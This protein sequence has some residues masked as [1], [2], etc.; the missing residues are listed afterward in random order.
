MD[1]SCIVNG[2]SWFDDRGLPVNA[3]GGCVVE[4]DK[5]YFFGEH[6]G[7]GANHFGGF[8]CY[9]SP[10]LTAWTFERM[11]LPRQADGLL[12]PNRIG[13]RP[14]VMRCPGTGE[15]VMFM[16]CDDDG[17]ADPC[18]GY[19]MADEI[20]GEYRFR[21]PLLLDGEPVRKWDIG[22]YQAPDGT[23]YLLFHE[24]TILQLSPDYTS[25]VEVVCADV[26]PGGEAPVLFEQDGVYFFLFSGKTAW[27]SNDNH[28]FTAPA[29][30][31]PWTPRGLFAP[32]G[33][34]THDSQATFVFRLPS[35]RP[36]HM[37]DRWSFPYQASAAT[38]VWLPLTVQGTR[39]SI[40]RYWQAWDPVA[41]TPVALEGDPLPMEFDAT[42]PDESIEVPFRGTRVALV[43][44]AAP[45][46]GYARVEITDDDGAVLVSHVVG[47]YS[48]APN[49]AVRFLSP[50]LPP[51]EHRIR[52]KPLGVGPEFFQK[53]GR[54]LGSQDTRVRVD[55]IIVSSS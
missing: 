17:Y 43:G 1:G 24:G 25:V 45:D 32:A 55:R 12:G 21:G 2:V 7:D 10:D 16:H 35:G 20:A 48:L 28:Y 18:V 30:E 34:L 6:K 19:A 13:E 15:F 37:G 29:L 50:E 49:D 46:G 14:K 44:H 31:G 8:S 22:S 47:F 27:D 33:S 9:S 54:R 42:L 23:G 36:V 26:A 39:L 38:Y 51:G 52:V 53:S 3:H 41:E 4:A 5:Y 40:P 11:A